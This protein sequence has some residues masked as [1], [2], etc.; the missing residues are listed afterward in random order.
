MSVNR[1]HHKTQHITVQ[2]HL[3]TE[4]WRIMTQKLY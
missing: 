1:A 3:R 4:T 2:T